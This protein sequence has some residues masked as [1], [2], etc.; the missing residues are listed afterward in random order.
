MQT[1]PLATVKNHAKQ[2]RD[3]N[4]SVGG[5]EGTYNVLQTDH[6]TEE[7]EHLASVLRQRELFLELKQL[8]KMYS[9]G[10]EKKPAQ[11]IVTST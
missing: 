5:G 7:S 4:N 1:N 2:T 9:E 6:R 11:V 8:F 10:E 3:G